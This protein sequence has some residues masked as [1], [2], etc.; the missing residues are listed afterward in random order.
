MCKQSVFDTQMSGTTAV[1]VLF[2]GLDVIVANC[3]DSRAVV[4]S[5]KVGGGLEVQALSQDQTPHRLDELKRCK[6]AGATVCNMAQLEG[7]EE[8]HERWAR[9]TY[10]PLLRT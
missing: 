9:P 6:A 7:D 8:M 4:A 2:D 1:T 10:A 5:T 3:G